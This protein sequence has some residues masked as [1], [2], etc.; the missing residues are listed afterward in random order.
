MAHFER[1]VQRALVAQQFEGM[2]LFGRL[3][4]KLVQQTVLLEVAQP[5][6][7]ATQTINRKLN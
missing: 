5:L 6:F 4:P 7:L 1:W 2:A 3:V